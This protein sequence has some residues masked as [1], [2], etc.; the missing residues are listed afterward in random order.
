[1]KKGERRKEE[2]L[3][4]AADLFAQKGYLRTTLNDII[5]QI[6]CSKGSFYHHFESKLQVLQALASQ[7]TLNA[8]QAYASEVPADPLQRLNRLL[9]Y[10][11]PFRAGEEQFLSSLLG[12][13]LQQEGAVITQH[14]RQSLK[15][16]FYADVV[17]T[18]EK[19]RSQGI[20]YYSN[21]A[22]PELLWEAHMAFVT[23]LTQEGCRLVISG[24]TPASRAVEMLG[25][26]RFLWERMLD[27]PYGS[28]DI[29][30]AEELLAT[31]KA[32]VAGVE[33]VQ[34]L[35]FDAGFAAPCQ[36]LPGTV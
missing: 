16:G 23:V 5:S 18:L 24:G 17:A 7:R 19:L 1:M 30:P 10:A 22:L 2:I 31:L 13:D 36:Q 21:A 3:Q 33:G 32:A 12:L 35:R 8:Y 9:Y 14:V 20:A 25:A 34:Q 4:T 29:L 15:N 26:T 27:I 28:M 11:F 6:G